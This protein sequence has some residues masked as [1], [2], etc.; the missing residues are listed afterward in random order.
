MRTLAK[1]GK[2][3]VSPQ[4]KPPSRLRATSAASGGKPRVAFGRLALIEVSG[5]PCRENTNDSSD[6]DLQH[7]VTEY[8]DQEYDVDKMMIKK[9]MMRRAGRDSG[10]VSAPAV[11]CYDNDCA[12]L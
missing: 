12:D 4:Q 1:P 7:R 11:R 5:E 2:P 3:A 10:P 9:V 6:K 8:Q